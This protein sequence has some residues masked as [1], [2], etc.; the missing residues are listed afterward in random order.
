V[1]L[2]ARPLQSADAHRGIG[3]Y[4][5]GL[6][7][8]LREE[9]F[10]HRIA[11]LFDAGMPTPPVPDGD[12]QAYTVRRRYRGRLGLIEE[13][14]IMGSR[15]AAIRPLLY[16]ATSLALPG[17]CP[18]P[19]LV[20]LH[21]LIP[22]A[23]GGWQ[24]LGERVRWWLG[25]RLLERAD[26]ILAPS[27]ATSRDAVQLARVK[28]DRVIVVPEGVAAGFRRAEGAQERVS[29]SYGID[30][31]YLLYV[32]ALDARKDPA[33]LLQA[34]KTVLAAGADVDLVLAGAAGRQAPADMGAARRLGYVDHTSLVDLYSAAACLVFPSRYEGFGL[35]LL[36]AMACGCPAVAYRNSSLPEVAGDAVLLVADGDVGALGSAAAEV[37]T[38]TVLAQRMR[39]DGLT[40]ARKFTWRK[41]ARAT[42]EVYE[43]LAPR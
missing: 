43:R 31:P 8:G 14:A 40:R 30:K 19:M 3:S 6:I 35:P 20:T 34:W 4:V 18:V 32:G 41:A 5:R 29:R 36:E 17:R 37:A 24:M 10:D 15:L 39:E 38:S 33:A 21:D 9:G 13:A 26:L 25:R 16:H 11:L 28:A 7:I 42:I 1:L 22:W 27:E 2:D 12:F 23:M